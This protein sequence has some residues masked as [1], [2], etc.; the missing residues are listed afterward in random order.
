M[1]TRIAINGSALSRGVAA[2]SLALGLTLGAVA[3]VQAGESPAKTPAAAAKSTATRRAATQLAPVKN[4]PSLTDRAVETMSAFHYEPRRAEW[5]A[6]GPD[7][8]K[9]LVAI[10][11]NPR[12]PG[13]IRERALKTLAVFPEAESVA[14]LTKL[15]RDPAQHELVR[16]TALD[17]LLRAAP[18]KARPVMIESATSDSAVV[19]ELVYRHI[20]Q[21]APE[22]APALLR[23]AAAS[24]KDTY[25]KEFAAQ[26]LGTLGTPAPA[27]ST[28]AGASSGGRR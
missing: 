22:A 9:V 17:S 11:E 21:V 6:L 3:D 23:D 15:A 13:P 26:K 7:M 4:G 25:L 20:G 5:D 1:T 24:E 12:Q 10:V 27:P 2:G 28:P 16:R 18:E 19:R 8:Q 14:L